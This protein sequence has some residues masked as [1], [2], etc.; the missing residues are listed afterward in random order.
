MGRRADTGIGFTRRDFLG[1]TASTVAGAYGLSLGL[2]EAATPSAFDGSR[3][4]LQAPEANAKHGGAMRYGVLSAPAHF[5]VHQSGTVS[6]MG[7]QGCMYD[8]LLRRRNLS[9]ARL[10]ARE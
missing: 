3:F 7:T 10:L 4:K 8:T 6:N 5:D 2:S 9:L 1:T